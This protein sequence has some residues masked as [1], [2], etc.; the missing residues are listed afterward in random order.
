MKIDYQKHYDHLQ[1]D[2][3]KTDWKTLQSSYRKLVNECHPDRFADDELMQANAQAKFIQITTSYNFLRD[4]YRKNRRLP[5]QRYDSD[6]DLAEYKDMNLNENMISDTSLLKKK[7]K[8][9]DSNRARKRSLR[10]LVTAL[11]GL[12]LV[13][14]IF[15]LFTLDK[16]GTKVAVDNARET[17]N[18]TEPSPFLRSQEQV[19]RGTSRG[20]FLE[21]DP[22]NGTL[23]KSRDRVFQ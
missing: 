6:E 9:I 23:G 22:A 20:V 2:Y 11:C 10:P 1:L 21:N 13:G 14:M 8:E 15:M 16:Y 5:L 17:I 18:S 12:M 4:F 19:S 7:R 3:Q